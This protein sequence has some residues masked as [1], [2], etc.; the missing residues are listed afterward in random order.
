MDTQS[1]WWTS[2]ADP[3][4][5][6]LTIKGALMGYIPILIIILQYFNV[7]LDNSIAVNDLGVLSVV[8]AGTMTTVGLIRKV[9]FS[10]KSL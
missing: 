4:Q 2:S 1:K 5:L 7:T 9:Y 6:A 8:I 10:I 3:T